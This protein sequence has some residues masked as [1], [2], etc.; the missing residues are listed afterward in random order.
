MEKIRLSILLCILSC[1]LIGIG[2]ASATPSL[3]FYSPTETNDTWINVNW[4]EVNQTITESS[5]DTFY[6]EW[7]YVEEDDYL[8]GH[9]KFEND[10]SYGENDTKAYDYSETGNNGTIINGTYV[11]GKS[12]LGL[13]FDGSTS[14]VDC[15]NDSS[16]D[17]TDAITIEAWVKPTTLL[18]VH[19][20][21]SN[22]DDLDSTYDG[23][24]ITQ[25]INRLELQVYNNHVGQQPTLSTVFLTINWNHI[26]MVFYNGTATGYING[27]SEIETGFPSTIGTCS[28]NFQIGR[29]QDDSYHFNG[30]IDEVRIYNTS[31]SA[32]QVLERYHSSRYKYYDDSLVLA[33]NFNNNS[34]IGDNSSY[35]IDISKYGNNGTFYGTT[36]GT[37]PI[38][39]T[40]KFGKALQFD[41]IDD[42]VDCGNDSS[43]DI[44]DA[45]TIEGWI[46]PNVVDSWSQSSIITHLG[47][48]KYRWKIGID[49]TTQLRFD[50]YKNQTT[51]VSPSGG[52]LVAGSW[53]HIV[54]ISDG[55]NA[56]IYLD[57][58]FISSLP[59]PYLIQDVNTPIYIGYESVN[60][61]YFNG[62]IDEGRIY[63][64]ALSPDE[65]YHH[66]NS[67]FQKYNSTEY[68]FY[69]NLTDLADGTYEHYGWANDTSGNE[70]SSEVRTLNVDVPPTTPVLSSPTDNDHTNDVTPSFDW[71]DSTDYY[72]IDKYNLVIANDTGFTVIEQNITNIASSAH[73]I[74][75][76]LSD[77]TYYWRTRANNTRGVNSEWATY[78][79][80]VID[81]VSPVLN[82]TA[83]A[84]LSYYSQLLNNITFNAT[85]TDANP[86]ILNFT[87]YNST[88]TLYSAQNS[89]PVGNSLSLSGTVDISSYPDGTYYGNW[90]CS[91]SHTGKNISD[92]KK[93]KKGEDHTLINSSDDSIHYQ[94]K[95]YFVEKEDKL[96][97]TPG[98]LVSYV[99]HSEDQT[100]IGFGLNF[101]V[102]KPETKIV[103]NI[104]V[105]GTTLSYLNDTGYRGHLI[106]YPYGTDFE[107]MLKVNGVEKT[108]QAIVT[109]HEECILVKIQPDENL[110]GNDVVEL[111]FDSIYGL[112]IVTETYTLYLDSTPPVC[113]SSQTPT[114]LNLSHFG[115][116]VTV[117]SSCSDISGVNWSSF[118]L[119]HDLCH[120][121][122]CNRTIKPPPSSL[123]NG[124]VYRG[125]NRFNATSHPQ[126]AFWWESIGLFSDIARF[127]AYDITTQKLTLS[128]SNSTHANF[129]FVIPFELT[130]HSEFDLFRVKLQSENKTDQTV[131]IYS[132][133]IFAKKFEYGSV[134][135]NTSYSCFMNT[136]DQ[137]SVKSIRVY[138]VNGSLLQYNDS[139]PW[140][141]D[142]S[143]L[144]LSET[145]LIPHFIVRN[146]TYV[147]EIRF[148]VNESGFIG[149]SKATGDFWLVLKTD[150]AAVG[151]AYLGAF[152]NNT[153]ITGDGMGFDNL[154][155]TYYSTDDGNTWNIADYSLDIFCTFAHADVDTIGRF[156]YVCDNLS[157]CGNTT[158][159]TDV[160]GEAPNH[161][162]VV[163]ITAPLEGENVSGVDNITWDASD[164]DAD[165]M[166]YTGYLCYPNGTINSTLFTEITNKYYEW[167]TTTVADG[168]WRIN[169]TATDEH[170]A[171]GSDISSNFTIDNTAPT[172][173]YHPP[174]ETNDTTIATNHTQV[175]MT[176]TEAGS[177]L[178][179]FKFNW[180]GTNYTFYN[181][182]LVLALNFNNN[183]A[184]G[185]TS[186][187]AVDISQYGN[188]GMFYGATNG[189]LPVHVT[190]KFGKALQFDGI[191]DYVDCGTDSSLN[192]TDAIT[193][194]A[195]V[196]TTEGGTAIISKYQPGVG[197]KRCY[198]MNNYAGY[199][200]FQASE[201]GSSE[202]HW[203]HDSTNTFND[204][205]WHHV[206]ATYNKTIL[207]L[208]IDGVGEDFSETKDIHFADNIVAIGRN[209]GNPSSY[210]NGSI[211]EVRIYNR[212]LPAD[213]IL[214]HY[215]SEL[216]K[217]NSTEYRFYANV[218]N[219][220]DGTQ[221]HYGWANDSAGNSN[222]SEIRTVTVDTTAPTTNATAVTDTGV[223]YSFNTWTNSSYVNVTLSC[224]DALAGC[225][226]TQYCTDT[227]NVC[228]PSTTYSTPVQIFT[229]NTSYIRFRSNDSMGNLETTKSETIK[230][231]TTAPTTNATA[232]DD[233]GSSYTFNTWTNSSYV[234]VTLSCDDGSGSGCN[235]TQYCT[236][237]SNVCTPNI[238]YSAPVHIST[239]NT[240]Y[241]RFRSNDTVGNLESTKSE[242]IRIDTTAPTVTLVSPPDNNWTL[243]DP[244]NFI[245]YYTNKEATANCKLYIDGILADT[246]ATTQNN[247]NT[248]LQGSGVTEDNHTW[249][250]NCT[251]AV[252]NEG[253]SAIR[254]I[255]VDRTK[256]SITL[257]SPAT[258]NYTSNNQP[259]FN[260]TATDNMDT[261]MDC[262]LFI[263]N[264]GY[265]TTTANNNT[266]TTITANDTLTDGI[267]YWNITCLDELQSN[268]SETRNITVDTQFPTVYAMSPLDNNWTNDSTINFIFN[269]TDNSA[270]LFCRLY[271]ND[272]LADANGTTLNNTPTTL[273]ASPTEGNH[274]W[275]V[276]CTDNASN[277]GQ[278]TPRNLLV[279]R[280]KP[281]IVLHTPL[282]NDVTT[283]VTPAFN[284]TT[285]DN[286]DAIMDCELF[287]D[288]IGY[289]TTTTNNN[290]PTT[291]TAND[292]LSYILHTWYINCSDELFTN[293]SEERN[294]TIGGN[295][296]VQV[297][298]NL[299]SLYANDTHD[300]ETLCQLVTGCTVVSKFENQKYVSHIKG[301]PFNIFSIV[302]GY[303]F[304]LHSNQVSTIPLSGSRITTPTQNI[305]VELERGWNILAWTSE[306]NTTAEA[307]CDDIPAQYIAK[308]SPVTGF[309]THLKDNPSNNFT[310]SEG[311][312]YFVWVNQ[313]LNWTHN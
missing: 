101:T 41:G 247:T 53:H 17:V 112:N 81:T 201:N 27:E 103:Y 66:Y 306:T 78:F 206:A 191:D 158:Y 33:L 300:S 196:K 34:A 58:T 70:N 217:Y 144:V 40:G 225:N 267:H 72:G 136:V 266:P 138:Y 163:Y 147:N 176:I 93:G 71:T 165:T 111:R 281:T 47:A 256:P 195:W 226:V 193:I 257:N 63:N 118:I 92:L 150:T 107:G 62:T 304:F 162:P 149:T 69:N 141:Y 2:T 171:N 272:V 143:T 127:S 12:G 3:T 139:D 80:M 178:D 134:D 89:S 124:G 296:S 282:N 279:D 20:I 232:V 24:A 228:T 59:F 189:T 270:T 29:Y 253:A 283:N 75:T 38:Y 82:A 15:G 170:G 90:S 159:V 95:A 57:G 97:D 132:S 117:V 222:T 106:W 126:Y 184:I 154:N 237:T 43:L 284:F 167:N 231:D 310:V 88:H 186:S 238:T 119:A 67:E 13:E 258:G 51:V 239:E 74:T 250:I 194:E 14:Y 131:P 242:T 213:E 274:T 164:P 190:G 31:L 28:S 185:E 243:D 219:L 121:G 269:V 114:D 285:T 46:K 56:K 259:T 6:H 249:Q 125:D 305:T 120:N 252:G 302:Q 113:T 16:L 233:T 312:G 309:T 137:N 87:F 142:Y 110:A 91:D 254:N 54:G 104:S 290:T 55:V 133:N 35:A 280:T 10:S 98:D 293:K 50:I 286:M 169:V 287:I 180:N 218:T 236:D 65:I 223:A 197:D 128:W 86:Y 227:S 68:R 102:L 108:Y 248:T 297:G 262:E 182:S 155:R 255:Y 7:N 26:V 1:I 146:S 49:N 100:R 36:N 161:A 85:C 160:L 152:A 122:D 177:G 294:L 207:S 25:N 84:N 129:T 39:T 96:T 220:S 99:E 105:D 60:I 234:N 52:T 299:L 276:N 295:V 174:T 313:T 42:Y 230:I 211:D 261:I 179:T 21:V 23:Y 265:G 61:R 244:I 48:G 307:V 166:N 140:D 224:S 94:M 9:W 292:T 153:N 204:G 277:T 271:I 175:N 45:I 64:R 181:D 172:L 135:V 298:W 303:G 200:R 263:D 209:S 130:L 18:G 205:E 278:S 199:L 148:M 260:F 291:I 4:T 22:F 235:V 168:T 215:Q 216:Q 123:A 157:N 44:T 273:T 173:T 202:A 76:N 264:I 5:L 289:G 198:V 308:Y 245:F 109:V 251:D 79:T 8:V 83:P 221:T 275:Y 37:L 151:K 241:I 115:E 203:E 116:N 77:G 301:L 32:D 183:T 188:N 11:T 19:R 268:T 156:A 214:L 208:Y 30:T 212:A 210:F 73:T 246:N 288:N 192:I 229:E 240:S 311:N 187:Y 145:D